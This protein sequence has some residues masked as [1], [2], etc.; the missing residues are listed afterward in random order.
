[1]EYLK[2]K[3]LG[4]NSQV[5]ISGVIESGIFVELENLAQKGVDSIQDY[6]GR[7]LHD[8]HHIQQAPGPVRSIILGN[9]SMSGLKK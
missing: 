8:K 4:R 7:V 1:M 2:E 5:F 9:Q 6:A 3:K